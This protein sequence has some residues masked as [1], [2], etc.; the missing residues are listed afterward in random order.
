MRKHSHR[1][2]LPVSTGKP[3]L[4]TLYAVQRAGQVA[5]CTILILFHPLVV[6]V[7]ATPFTSSTVSDYVNPSIVTFSGL[8]SLRFLETS[9]AFLGDQNHTKL[10]SLSITYLSMQFGGFTKAYVVYMKPYQK[11]PELFQSSLKRFWVY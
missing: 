10:Y 1:S 4:L 2:P 6:A 8:L 11:L 7:R 5:L 3:L 9:T